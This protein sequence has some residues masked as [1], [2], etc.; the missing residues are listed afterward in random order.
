MVR[1]E[2][3]VAMTRKVL[4]GRNHACSCSRERRSVEPRGQP[5]IFTVRANVDDWIV[6]IVVDVEDRSVGT[7]TPSAR[8]SSA[9]MRPCSY[10]GMNRS[11]ADG[12][13]RR[14]HHGTAEIDAIRHEIAAARAIASSVLEVGADITERR[15]SLQSHS[16]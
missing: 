1:V 7:C 10:A 4:S 2:I 9:V 6:R 13:L 16:A 11:R 8:P 12:N 15:S 14:K 3:G 5:W